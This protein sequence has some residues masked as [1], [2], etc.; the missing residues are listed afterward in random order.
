MSIFKYK[1][2]V[3]YIVYGVR[4]QTSVLILRDPKVSHPGRACGVCSITWYEEHHTL[5]LKKV[6]SRCMVLLC[7]YDLEAI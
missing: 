4:I 3:I 5:Y 6:G 7:W 1:F 2:V